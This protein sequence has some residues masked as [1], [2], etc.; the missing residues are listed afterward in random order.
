M[1]EN[2][3]YTFLACAYIVKVIILMDF[4]IKLQT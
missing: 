2:S 1:Q 3:V 4:V